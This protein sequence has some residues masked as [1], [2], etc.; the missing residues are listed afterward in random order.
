MKRKINVEDYL[1][2]IDQSLQPKQQ[3]EIYM[4]YIMVFAGF[5]AFSY[6]LFWNTSLQSFESKLKHRNN[7]KQKIAR[8]ETYLKSHPTTIIKGIDKKIEKTKNEVIKYKD[9]NQYIK[10]QLEQISFL[11]YDERAW[12]EYLHS[13]NAKADRYKVKLLELNNKVNDTG[14]SFGHVLDISIKSEARYKNLLK[15]INE[16]EK[17]DLVVDVHDIDIEA[18]S[19]LQSDVNISVWGIKY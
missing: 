17:S 2:K 15:F 1:H 19:T 10:I 9:Y 3:K 4:I 11:L 5:F 14:E 8:D 18:N 13:I 7:L 6:L 12:G 16:L